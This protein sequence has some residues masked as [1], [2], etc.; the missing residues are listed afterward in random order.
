MKKTNKQSYSIFYFSS[1][2]KPVINGR[3][4]NKPPIIKPQ[5]FTNTYISNLC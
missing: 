2:G 5:V 1:F 3:G 4:K